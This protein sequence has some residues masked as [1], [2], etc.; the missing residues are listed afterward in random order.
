MIV[1]LESIDRDMAVNAMT[2]LESE[3]FGRGAWSEGMVREELAAPAR[4]YVFDREDDVI[5][6]YAGYWYDGEDAELMTI[7]V[8]TSW[9]RSGIAGALL[10]RLID[11]A[12]KQGARRML[13]E[14]RV[15]NESALHLYHKFGFSRLGL[16]RRYY[17]PEGIDA[18][19]MALDLEPR[20][21]GF[22][23]T[24]LSDKEQATDHSRQ[25]PTQSSMLRAFAAQ[26]TSKETRNE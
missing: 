4:T 11:S 7:G 23:R 24:E 16:R 10:G 5:R 12:R 9:Q 13:L 3:L 20:V 25:D 19:T 21:V 18:Y 17:Q 1:D 6:G 8:G 15:D 26:L 14:V 2:K 22:Q